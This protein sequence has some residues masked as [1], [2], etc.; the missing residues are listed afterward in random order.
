MEPEQVAGALATG[1][2][3]DFSLTALFLRATLMVQVTMVALVIASIWSWAIVVA[4]TLRFRRET[5]EAGRF[6]AAFWSGQPLDELHERLGD[7]AR[8]ALERVFSAGMGEWRK[9]HAAGGRLIPGAESR[10]ERAMSVVI[11]RETEALDSRL[12]VLASVGAVT[13]FVGLFGTVWGIKNSFEQIALQESAN[14][15]VVAPG[16]AEAL[17][18]TAL[19][20]LAAIPAVIFY[21]KLS[22]DSDRLSGR[23]ETFADE[24]GTILNRQMLRGEG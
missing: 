7:R 24:F 18:S 5:S 23:M 16:I 17:L 12:S 6:E 4:K 20:L 22:G 10:I 13:P 9:S 2:E 1:R 19:G 3:L 21:N 14:L 11:Q 8:S 15:V